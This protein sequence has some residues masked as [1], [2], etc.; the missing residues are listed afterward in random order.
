MAP[1]ALAGVGGLACEQGRPRVRAAARVP[2][3]HPHLPLASPTAR[4]HAGW[5]S[6]NSQTS[7]VSW[8]LHGPGPAACA[9][10]PRR[11][12]LA[13]V[14][15]A[16]TL[17]TLPRTTPLH[18]RHRLHCG[19]VDGLPARGAAQQVKLAGV[20]RHLRQVGWGGPPG[21]GDQRRPAAA[22]GRP[23]ATAVIITPAPPP[24]TQL[25]IHCRPD[26][27]LPSRHPGALGLAHRHCQRCAPAKQRLRAR[28][29][30][31][32]RACSPRRRRLHSAAAAVPAP[33][34][35]CACHDVL[36]P[37]AIAAASAHHAPADGRAAAR[38]YLHHGFMLDLIAVVP[39]IV[40]LIIILG[41]VNQHQLRLLYIMRLLRLARCAVRGWGAVV[42][43]AAPR[44]RLLLAARQLTCPPLR[45]CRVWRLL[46]SIQPGRTGGPFK[47]RCCSAGP[48]ACPIAAGGAA[49]GRVY[50]AALPARHPTESP[51]P[52]RH[53]CVVC[54]ACFR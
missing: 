27:G 15:A 43:A 2:A 1:G 33:P 40:Q 11:C 44:V 5:P 24:P 23:V 28:R 50:G 26:C 14:V 29:G 46:A 37:H 52:T 20:L 48:L 49:G 34:F 41:N 6:P 47:V 8:P 25:Y 3:A 19:A 45:G 10:L 7:P 16:R 21:F 38:F 18:C 51:T 13:P 54:R 30:R 42:C 12:L 4:A 39:S 36:T 31:A 22:G 17:P 32:A 9:C 35:T 53:P